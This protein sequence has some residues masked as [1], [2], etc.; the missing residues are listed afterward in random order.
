LPEAQRDIGVVFVATLLLSLLAVIGSFNWGFFLSASTLIDEE[1]AAVEKA[2]LLAVLLGSAVAL[3]L[4][5]D[6]AGQLVRGR[7]K[8]SWKSLLLLAV[9]ALT[10]LP[11]LYIGWLFLFSLL[12]PTDSE[13]HAIEIAEGFV[14]RNGYTSTGHPKDLPVLQ[15]D[16]MD[17][18]AG[19]IDSLLEM[20]RGTLQSR[21]FSVSSAGPGITVFFE[22]IPPRNHGPYRAVEVGNEGH[23]E[24]VH[25]DMYPGLANRRIER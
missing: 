10:A 19:S 17:P 9:A 20:R 8:R 18:L 3:A 4:A 5:V 7:L 15:N 13:L 24:I 23:A 14:E 22:S 2:A 1:G 12:P 11:G 25:Q 16:I 6:A 21:A